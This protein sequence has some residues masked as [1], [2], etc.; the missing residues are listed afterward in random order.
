MQLSSTTPS[1]V[2]FEMPAPTTRE[3]AA[4]ALVGVPMGI[5]MT[6][7]M[8][9]MTKSMAGQPASRADLVAPLLEKLTAEQAGAAMQ[10]AID[11]ALQFA[12]ELAE[13]GDA[14]RQ[15]AAG[16]QA[17]LVE[18]AGDS[19]QGDAQQSLERL[20]TPLEPFMGPLMEAA[21]LLD[22]SLAT[23]DQG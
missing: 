3:E 14:L 8:T 22:P 4:K 9:A 16:V 20:M 21:L 1:S 19:V 7:T 13:R 12:P 6:A 18:A 5:A 17:L 10:A 11:G 23:P 15:A 2:R